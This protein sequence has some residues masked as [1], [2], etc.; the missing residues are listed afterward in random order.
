MGVPLEYSILTYCL[1]ARSAQSLG[2]MHAYLCG[3]AMGIAVVIVFS[4]AAVVVA[5]VAVVVVVEDGLES[6]LGGSDRAWPDRVGPGRAWGR[7]DFIF[8]G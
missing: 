7:T 1:R 3:W 8:S 2:N 6:V 4:V 5:A